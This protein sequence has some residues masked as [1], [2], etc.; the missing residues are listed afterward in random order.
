[1]SDIEQ[2]FKDEGLNLYRRAQGLQVTDQV[3]YQAAGEFAKG[4]KDLKKKVTDYFAPLKDAAHKA[5]KSVTQREKEELEPIE[6]ADTVVRKAMTDYLNE[7]ECIRKE[8]QARLEREAREAAEKER[9]KLLDQAVKAEEKG[10]DEKAEA[11]FEKAENVYVEPVFAES[12]VEKTVQL[13]G[14]GRATAAKDVR[15][16]VID[17]RAFIAAIAAGQVPLTVVEI[18]QSTL[19]SWAKSS[20]LKAVPGC[21]VEEVLGVRI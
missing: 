9:Q 21:K 2:T 12:T 18:K 15:I 17:M 8:E 4:L 14:G 7:Q 3:T 13:S 1:M 16:T 20:G 19:K 10:K 11:L 5:H 6:D